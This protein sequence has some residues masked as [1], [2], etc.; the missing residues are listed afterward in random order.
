MWCRF[1]FDNKQ[2][3]R[4][5]LYYVLRVYYLWETVWKLQVYK[6]GSKTRQNGVV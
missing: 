6:K 3:H 1:I 4:K 5:F 2:Q